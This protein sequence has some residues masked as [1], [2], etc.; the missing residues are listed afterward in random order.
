MRTVTYEEVKQA[1]EELID[2]FPHGRNEDLCAYQDKDGKP[3][4]AVGH[5]LYRLGVPFPNANDDFRCVIENGDI[6]AEFTSDAIAFLDLFQTASDTTEPPLGAKGLERKR[7]RRKWQ[8]TFSDAVF[9][10]EGKRPDDK[11]HW[12]VPSS[13]PSD[14]LAAAVEAY[15]EDYAGMVYQGWMG[16]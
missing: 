10:V 15:G 6:D 8:N 5:V 11:Q 2:E 4:C 14:T 16:A 9:Y 7:P 12:A 1:A 13:S 3:D